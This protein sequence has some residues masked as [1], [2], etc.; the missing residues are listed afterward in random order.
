MEIKIGNRITFKIKTGYYQNLLTPEMMIVLGSIKNKITKDENSENMPQLENT[1]VVL[2]YFNIFNNEYQHVSRALYKFVPNKSFGQL[3][4]ILP[5]NVIFQKNF[6]S[7]F[8]YIEVALT[9]QNSKL[10]EIEDKMNITVA[11]N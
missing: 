6:N 1:E 8:S 2:V 4:D 10:L 9:D 5:K 11:I 3:S 7:E